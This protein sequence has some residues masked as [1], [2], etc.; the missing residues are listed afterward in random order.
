M[1]VADH[2]AQIDDALAG[3]FVVWLEEDRGS[4]DGIVG[5]GSD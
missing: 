4:G 2:G 1:D 5:T 3:D